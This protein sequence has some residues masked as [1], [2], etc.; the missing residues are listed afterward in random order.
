MKPIQDTI[1]FW[2]RSTSAR[3]AEYWSIRVEGQTAERA[4]WSYPEPTPRFAAIA[5]HLAFYAS[6]VDRCLVGDEVV[7]AQAGDF[8]GGWITSRVTG[9][10]KGEPGT[11]GW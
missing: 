9:P 4:A 5:G 8:Y 2:R 7:S 6:R 10:F 11:M 3:I 1:S